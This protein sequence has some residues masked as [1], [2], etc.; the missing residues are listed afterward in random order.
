MTYKPNL[1]ILEKISDNHQEIYVIKIDQATLIYAAILLEE[2]VETSP[3]YKRSSKQ[4]YFKLTTKLV[5]ESEVVDFKL[6]KAGHKGKLY[7][8]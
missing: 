4:A 3:E 7:H 1:T 6:W 2:G 5:P 8:T